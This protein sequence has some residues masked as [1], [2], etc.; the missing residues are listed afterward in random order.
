MKWKQRESNKLFAFMIFEH[1]N[2]K[3][4]IILLYVYLLD[5]YGMMA[6]SFV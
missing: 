4:R 3:N 6:L 5:G 2:L 1:L